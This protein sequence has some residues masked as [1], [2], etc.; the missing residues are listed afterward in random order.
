MSGS[1]SRKWRGNP[2]LLKATARLPQSFV[3]E[4]RLRIIKGQLR[5]AMMQSLHH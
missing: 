2:D 4:R 1:W 3:I 5:N